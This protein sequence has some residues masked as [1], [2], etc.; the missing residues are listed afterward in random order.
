MSQV[1]E[2]NAEAVGSC[3]MLYM[4]YARIDDIAVFMPSSYE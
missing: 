1:G 3:V 4:Q 2:K